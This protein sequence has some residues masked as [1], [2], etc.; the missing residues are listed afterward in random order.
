MATRIVIEPVTRIEG[1]AKISLQLGDDGRV[2]DARFHVG[3]FRGFE[4]FCEGRPFYEMPTLTSRVCGICPVS[5]LI[6][7]AKACDQILSVHTPSPAR[8]LRRLMNLAQIIQSHALSFF[9]LSSPDLVLGME[10]DPARRNLFGLISFDEQY[11][12]GGIRLRKFGQEII[13][14]LGGKRIHPGGVVPGGMAA[15]LSEE[16][17]AA[18][19]SHVSEAR[20]IALSALERW[21]EILDRMAEEVEVFG[22]FPTL[23]VGLVTPEGDWEYYEGNLSVMDANGMVIAE[24]IP[25]IEYQEYFAERVD[26]GSYMKPAY[27]RPRG[28]EA[29]VYR[30]GALARLNLCRKMGV[31]LADRELAEYRHRFPPPVASSFLY[32]HARLIEILASVEHISRLLDDE[33]IVATRVRAEARVNRLEAVGVSEAPRGTLF[34][35]YKVNEDGL[36]QRVNLLIATGQNHGAMNRTILQIARHY[37]KGRDI[38]EGILNRI[39]AGIRAFDPCLSCSTH[40]FGQMPLVVELLA[41]DGAVVDRVTRA[42]GDR[43]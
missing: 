42:S 40:A 39:E 32:H 5:H 29:G 26:T 16:G 14:T 15:P 43:V 35:H 8:K 41:A 24:N 21:K 12:R 6:A 9:H 28:E 4:K 2:A 7:S 1:H 19:Q 34:H 23:Y 25:P 38:P 10:S 37:V 22:R 27:Y 3:E 33:E 17:R 13:E 31:P 36:I 18:I 11:A 20:A 30:V